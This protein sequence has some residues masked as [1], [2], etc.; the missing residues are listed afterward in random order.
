[1]HASDGG[2]CDA[3]DERALPVFR[4]VN[5]SLAA[6]DSMIRDECEERLD[7]S[8]WEQLS[9]TANDTARADSIAEA[10]SLYFWGADGS[11]AWS[12]QR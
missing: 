5:A 8:L 7:L 1:M 10:R 6:R 9:R 11:R 12:S 4:S 2:D 3:S